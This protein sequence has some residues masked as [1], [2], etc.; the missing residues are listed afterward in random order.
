MSPGIG[1]RITSGNGVLDDFTSN[2]RASDSRRGDIFLFA[3]LDRDLQ[4]EADG[5]GERQIVE[6]ALPFL[7]KVSLVWVLDPSGS[8]IQS[9]LPDTFCHL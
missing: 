6:S 7:I 9:R 8:V 3:W 2:R 5:E 1:R 4:D